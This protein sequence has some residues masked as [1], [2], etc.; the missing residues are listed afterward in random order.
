MV[1]HVFPPQLLALDPVLLNF[2]QNAAA[3]QWMH[4]LLGTVLLLAA[5]Y[6]F[7]RVRRAGVDAASRRL[8]G[9]LFALI[10][11]QYGLGVLTLLWG[12]PVSLAVIHQATALAIVGVWV[13]WAH[14]VRN[15][16]LTSSAPFARCGATSSSEHARPMP[17]IAARMV[18]SISSMTSDPARRR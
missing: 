9:A 3:V 5:C 14:H 2:V 6:F 11:V 13:A 4:R 12:V 8:N 16:A 17:S 15:I 18:M 1:G 10:G 7:V